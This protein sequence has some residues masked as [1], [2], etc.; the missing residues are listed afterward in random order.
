MSTQ[1][2]GIDLGVDCAIVSAPVKYKMGAEEWV[3][4]QM[5]LCLQG[6]LA[7]ELA[8]AANWEHVLVRGNRVPMGK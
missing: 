5:P 7:G 2:R 4:R 3:E 8:G 1:I 6:V